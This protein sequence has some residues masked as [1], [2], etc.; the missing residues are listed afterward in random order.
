MT[1]RKVIL[2]L[3]ALIALTIP[4]TA[5]AAPVRTVVNCAKYDTSDGLWPYVRPTRCNTVFDGLTHAET[6]GILH[7]MRWRSWGGS[8]AVAT[9]QARYKAYDRTP[10]TIRLSGRK[11]CDPGWEGG[12]WYVYTRLTVIVASGTSHEAMPY[13]CPLP[14]A[15]D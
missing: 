8:V 11:L 1:M 9:G 10:A 14:G 4:A 15:L 5:N 12:P 2:T 13:N 6:V 7:K 3:T